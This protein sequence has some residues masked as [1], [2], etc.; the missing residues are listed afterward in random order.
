MIIVIIVIIGSLILIQ[1]NISGQKIEITQNNQTILI[2]SQKS[3][4]ENI[5]PV[6]YVLIGGLFTFLVTEYR[7]IK[8]EE[9]VVSVLKTDIKMNLDILEFNRQKVELDSRVKGI[10]YI[11]LKLFKIDFWE[12]VNYN[13]PK[14][15]ISDDLYL[16]IS[17]A[18]LIMNSFNEI[19]QVREHHKAFTKE[20]VV[21]DKI[22]NGILRKEIANLS[23]LLSEI[24]SSL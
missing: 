22:F 23:E 1:S 15:I 13:L 6:I 24:D 16:K 20:K 18:V 3:I 4:T 19:N 9:K 14:K 5:F 21:K 8:T 17:R 12:L 2:N 10:N 11:P 7:S